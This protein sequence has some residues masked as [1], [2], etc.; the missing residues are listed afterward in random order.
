[1]I[2]RER[3][4]KISFFPKDQAN[5]QWFVTFYFAHV[6]CCSKFIMLHKAAVAIVLEFIAKG[7]KNNNTQKKI[8]C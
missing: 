4:K 2:L 7:K 3:I 6:H 5:E 1:M 8:A